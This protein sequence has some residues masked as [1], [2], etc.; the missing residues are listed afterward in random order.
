MMKKIMGQ[1][2]LFLCLLLTPISLNYAYQ[3][4][5][6][7]YASL[8]WGE[9][10]GTVKQRYNTSFIRYDKS[11]SIYMVNIPNAGGELGMFG[12]VYILCLF[13]NDRLSYILI[14]IPRQSSQIEST[15]QQKISDIT[16]V[17]GRPVIRNG[18]AG[19]GGRTT[20]ML[21]DKYPEGVRIQLIPTYYASKFVR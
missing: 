9:S 5:P 17:C 19:W 12:R 20:I 15:Y 8:Y 18:V 10:L 7:G 1:I 11:G 13:D 4:E 3:N 16:A 21:V 2:I 6:S 14:P